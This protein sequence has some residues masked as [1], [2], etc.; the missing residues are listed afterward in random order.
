[1]GWWTDLRDTVETGAVLAG[2]YVLPGSSLVTS[3]LVS[4]GSQ[5]QLNSDL[6]ILAQ[7]GT[8]GA[9]AMEGNLANYQTAANSVLS[10]VPSGTSVES[11]SQATGLTGP[12]LAKLGITAAS[13]LAGGAAVANAGGGTGSLNMAQQDRSGFSSG[14]ANYSPEYYQQIQNKYNQ[15]MPQAKGADITTDLKNWYDTKYTP[16][17]AVASAPTLNTTGTGY[18][19][20]TSMTNLGIKPQTV[21]PSYSLLT[22]D[23]SSIDDIAAEYAKGTTTMGGNTQAN[24]DTALQYLKSKG[25]TED[26][27]N[28]AYNKYLTTL[29]AATGVAPVANS[30]ASQIA[31][32]YYQYVQQQGGHSA[33]TQEAAIKFLL[34]A[35]VPYSTIEQAGGLFTSKYGAA[36]TASP[37]VA[38][39]Q[40]NTGMLTGQAQAPAATPSQP[41]YTSLTSS[42]SPEQIA[43]AYKE[44]IASA[45]GDT[46]A[47]QQV[48]ADYLRGLGLND[49]TI[50]QG[51]GLF[52]G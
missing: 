14:S 51:Y 6:G 20:P 32:A 45:G 3:K 31:D 34:D 42:S 7:L 13:L 15:Y 37:T 16:N 33:A 18:T 47:N 38:P 39:T 25:F 8:G 29:P 12:Q 40:A 50:A 21:A 5:E 9:G 22:P 43:A 4:N 49:T 11:I 17:A 1:M 35:G 19:T 24:R 27:W 46:Q 26:Q 2:N 30:S 23:K 48:A 36:P 10:S 28:Q 44:A 52:K 41:L